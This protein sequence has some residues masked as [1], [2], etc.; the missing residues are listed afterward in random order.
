[1]RQHAVILFAID[2]LSRSVLNEPR[3]NNA[4]ARGTHARISSSVLFNRRH[5]HNR[6]IKIARGCRTRGNVGCGWTAARM[7]LN[8]EFIIITEISFVRGSEL[9]IRSRAH[10]R[11]C[12]ADWDL[13]CARLRE[14]WNDFGNETTRVKLTIDK[15]IPLPELK[16]SK[17]LF[18]SGVAQSRRVRV[19]ATRIYDALFSSK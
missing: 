15:R 2:Y 7:R 16:L 4:I 1:M 3:R 13:A 9:I 5:R 14:T 19:A 6:P 8:V 18:T 12:N 11:L 17:V 10:A